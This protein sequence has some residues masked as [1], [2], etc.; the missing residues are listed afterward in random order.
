MN[1]IL[2]YNLFCSNIGLRKFVGSIVRRILEVSI[3]IY[4][5]PRDKENFK[6]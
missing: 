1:P 4:M 5:C 2:N 3:Y 6:L